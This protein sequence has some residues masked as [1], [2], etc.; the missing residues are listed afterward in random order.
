MDAL[1]LSDGEMVIISALSR[2]Q[3]GTQV[4][5]ASRGDSASYE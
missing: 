1:G 5:A 3:N 2:L 4:T